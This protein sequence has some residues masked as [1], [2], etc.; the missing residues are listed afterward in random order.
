MKPLP[1]GSLG[2]RWTT[3]D[4]LQSTRKVNWSLFWLIAPMLSLS[5]D[6]WL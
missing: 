5:S 4:W 6:R 1:Q 3:L 2:D